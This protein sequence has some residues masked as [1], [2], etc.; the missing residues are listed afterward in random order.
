MTGIINT[1]KL[2]FAV[3]L[4]KITETNRE[5]SIV[6]KTVTLE[7]HN[8]CRESFFYTEK[9]TKKKRD[10]VK[11]INFCCIWEQNKCFGQ[12][13]TEEININYVWNSFAEVL[14]SSVLHSYIIIDI[15]T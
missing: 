7:E 1:E 11:C 13:R 6:S 14:T 3:S 8:F 15:I 4:T 9:F 2:V 5:T 12:A 10:R